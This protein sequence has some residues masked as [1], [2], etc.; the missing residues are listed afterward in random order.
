M[1]A[2]ALLALRW[3]SGS[4]LCLD[5]QAKVEHLAEELAAAQDARQLAA[6]QQERLSKA[7]HAAKQQVTWATTFIPQH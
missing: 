3:H 5:P 7:L 6:A 2:A 1:H 4:M